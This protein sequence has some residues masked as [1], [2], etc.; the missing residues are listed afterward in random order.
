MKTQQ[1]HYKH[2]QKRMRKRSSMRNQKLEHK[3]P[4]SVQYRSSNHKRFKEEEAERGHQS[5]KQPSNTLSRPHQ[6]SHTPKSVDHFSEY[7]SSNEIQLYSFSVKGNYLEWERTMD[8]WLCYNRI[9]KK[10][11]LAFAISQFTGSAYKWWLQEEDYCWFYK[12]SI[13]TTW[14]SLKFLLRS[15]YASKGHTSLKSPMKKVTSTTDFRREKSETKM[16]DYEKEIRS[17]DKEILNNI[18]THLDKKRKLINHLDKKRKLI[19]H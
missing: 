4:D 18:I 14:E 8:K 17:L 12:E 9:L 1:E 16:A 7:K 3:P 6:S 11:R 5:F 19:K 15:K 2:M 10:K 13:I